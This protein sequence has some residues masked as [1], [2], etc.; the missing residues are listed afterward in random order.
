MAT[1]VQLKHKTTGAVRCL[2]TVDAR[3]LLA[4]PEGSSWEFARQL[5]RGSKMV[6]AGIASEVSEGGAVEFTGERAQHAATER[7]L[8]PQPEPT[9]PPATSIGSKRGQRGGGPQEPVTA[10]VE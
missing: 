9:I 1:I 4:S 7:A 6:E 2:Y 8:L 10:P 3:E 5:A